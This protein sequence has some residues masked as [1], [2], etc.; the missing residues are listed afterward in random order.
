[1]TESPADSAIDPRSPAGRSAPGVTRFDVPC[2]SH[3]VGTVVTQVRRWA[4]DRA[5]PHVACMRLSLLTCAAMRHGLRFDPQEVTLLLRW[6]DAERVRL[7]VRW[8]GCSST[9][10]TD[11][12]GQEV[13]TTIATLDALAAEWGVELVPSGWV[14]WM[15]ADAAV[16]AD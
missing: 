14:L 1:M 13:R 4:S 9:A 6:S 12:G 3:V 11:A 16:S 8:R 15:V 10:R 2:H 7:D 5:L